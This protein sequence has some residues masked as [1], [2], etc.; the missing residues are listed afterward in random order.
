[1]TLAEKINA[2]THDYFSW[3]DDVP[4]IT[5]EDLE[6]KNNRRTLYEEFHMIADDH[7]NDNEVFYKA[8]DICVDLIEMERRYA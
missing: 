6:K 2:F 5:D 8:V 1:M 7:V 3:W 4:P